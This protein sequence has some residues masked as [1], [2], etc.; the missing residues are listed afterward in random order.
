MNYRNSHG[1]IPG[2]RDSKCHAIGDHQTDMTRKRDE[3][4][5]RVMHACTAVSVKDCQHGVCTMCI[6]VWCVR[7]GWCACV[8]ANAQTKKIL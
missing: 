1:E 2:F 6:R 7:G 5:V 4:F 3:N 8:R